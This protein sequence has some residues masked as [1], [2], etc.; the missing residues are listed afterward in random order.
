MRFWGRGVLLGNAAV[1]LRVA[2]A[3]A[4]GAGA[5]GATHSQVYRE[6]IRIAVSDSGD[7]FVTEQQTAWRIQAPDTLVL[8]V[9]STLRVV[10]VAIDGRRSSWGRAGPEVVI[11]QHGSVGDTLVTRVRFHGLPNGHNWF[12]IPRDTPD[13]APLQL[14]VEVPPGVKPATDEMSKAVLEGVDSLAYGR[15]N[16]RF[17]FPQPVAL[18]RLRL[19]VA[20]LPSP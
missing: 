9:D 5:T 8:L 10:R 17:R 11:P 1:S 3:L 18:G 7:H 16:W 13:L 15:T 4:Q 19:E 2:A 6:E 20:R 14:A 12:A